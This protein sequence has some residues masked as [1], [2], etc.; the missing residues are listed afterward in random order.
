M[1]PWRI[2]SLQSFGPLEEG[3]R[4]R[5]RRSREFLIHKHAAVGGD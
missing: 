2:R 5:D 1:V 3:H 4:C